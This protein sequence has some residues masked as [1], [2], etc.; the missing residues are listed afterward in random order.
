MAVDRNGLVV[1]DRGE[2]LTLLRDN[3]LGRVAV[4]IDA[5]P[6]ILPVQYA[7]LGDDAIVF[8]TSIG[9]K[10]DAA[11]Q[12]AV[13]AFEVDSVDGLYHRGWSVL[14]TGRAS[15]VVDP[16]E[17]FR[18]EALHLRPWLPGEPDRYVKVATDVVSGR[19]IEPTW[20][21]VAV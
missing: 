8:R 17:L 18:C 1:L 10:L 11:L 2:C 6:V 14:V 4:S 9:T 5:L 15:E 19:L 13:V 12:S 16:D 7:V 21:P 20:C 3:H